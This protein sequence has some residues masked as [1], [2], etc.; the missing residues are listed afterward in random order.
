MKTKTIMEKPYRA[1]TPESTVAH[2]PSAK[3]ARRS[4][5]A[6][7]ERLAEEM[8]QVRL[9]EHLLLVNELLPGAE[10]IGAYCMGFAIGALRNPQQRHW[11]TRWLLVRLRECSTARQGLDVMQAWYVAPGRPCGPV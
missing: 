4:G 3:P 11:P 6:D 5:S 10:P 8:F 2:A 9:K 7:I 1:L